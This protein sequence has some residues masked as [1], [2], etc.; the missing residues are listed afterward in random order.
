MASAITFADAESVS[1]RI[2][3]RRPY[4]GSCHCGSI[5]YIAFI[6]LP[7]ERTLAPAP[8]EA[9]PLPPLPLTVAYRCNCTTCQKAGFFHVRFAF[10][11]DDFALLAPLDPMTELADYTCF[12]ERLHWLFC[13]RCGV[14][15]FTLDGSGEVAERDMEKDLGGKS[16]VETIKGLQKGNKEGTVKVWRPRKEGWSERG[17]DPGRQSYFSLNAYT[18]EAGQEGL[19][20]REWTEEKKVLYLD[21]LEPEGEGKGEVRRYE[22]PH[23]GGAY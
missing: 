22:R 14:R 10:A 9:P 23:Y 19:D 11:P 1:K 6:T 15:C 20:L 21:C 13:R 16:F 3:I 4:R 7:L 12:S 5:Q 17:S 18:L 2:Y 8:G